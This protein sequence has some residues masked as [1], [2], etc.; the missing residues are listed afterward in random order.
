LGPVGVAAEQALEGAGVRPKAHE[1]GPAQG[2][3]LDVHIVH[4]RDLEFAAPRRLGAADVLKDAR[5]VQVQPRNGIVA[6]GIV[7]LFLDG[8]DPGGIVRVK[9]GHAKAL[10]VGHLAQEDQGSPGKASD[11]VRDVG[12]GGVVTQDNGNVPAIGKVLA[13]AEG[14]GDAPLVFLVGVLQMLQPQLLPVLEH[15]DEIPGMRPA[16]DDNHLGDPCLHQG[17]DGVEH[18][19]L[20]VHRQEVLVGGI[21][22]GVEPGGQAPGEDD[23]FHVPSLLV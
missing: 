6:L 20:I 17:A 15:A 12:V 7:R 19:G 2:A 9:D 13:Q 11:R 10:R 23:S 21:G 14:F 3:R 4:V 16:G 1:L 5:I 8:D 18:H 22:E